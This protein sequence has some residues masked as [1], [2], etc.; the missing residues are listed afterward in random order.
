MLGDLV[1]DDSKL[2]TQFIEN[3]VN[4]KTNTNISG[5][6]SFDSPMKNHPCIDG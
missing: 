4:M 3:L 1:F 6:Y 5:I 2:K